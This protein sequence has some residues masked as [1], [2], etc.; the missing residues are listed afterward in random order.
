MKHANVYNSCFYVSLSTNG[1][2][3]MAAFE[4][5]RSIF[6][7]LNVKL[8][9]TLLSLGIKGYLV[10]TGW[11]NSFLKEVPV[12]QEDRY[13][14]WVTYSYIDFIHERLSKQQTVFEYGTGYSTQYYAK[15]TNQV[16]AIEHDISW[17][18]RLK[19]IVPDNVEIIQR[20][21]DYDGAYCRTPLSY[22][23][24]FH[25]V[26]VDG[27]DRINCCKQAIHALTNDGVIVLDDSERKEYAA[28]VAFL[29][30]SGF[31]QLKFSGMAPGVI[32]KKE[33]SVFYRTQNCLEI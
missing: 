22:G 18:N 11:I 1:N 25:L 5:K 28:A 20:P 31:K 16:K 13:I 2:N 12:D 26:V 8:I 4:K 15:H 19:A 24:Q 23:K 14:P 9:R 33:T 6:K 17:Y 29:K 21:L 27:R 30:S 10:D 32:L 7:L 3:K